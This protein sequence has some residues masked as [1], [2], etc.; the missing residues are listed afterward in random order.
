MNSRKKTK[1]VFVGPVGIGGDN[2]V[3]IQS[4]TNTPTENID[5]TVAQIKALADAG[6]QIIRV[7]LP[8]QKA[9]KAFRK[10]KEQSPIPV[11]ADIH[12]QASY[13]VAAI[14]AGADKV[15]IN[16]GNIGGKEKVK[17]VVDAARQAG[18]PIRIGVNS[19]SVEKDILE[20]YGSPTP[21]ALLE[22]ALRYIAMMES[23]SFDTIVLSIKASDVLTTIDACRL[24][25]EHCE[26]P[27]HIGITESGTVRTGTIRSSVGVGALLAEGIGDTIRVSLSGDPVNEIYVAREVLKSLGLVSGPVVIACPTC[28]RT[29]IDV[30]SLAEKVEAMVAGITAPIKIAVMGCVVNG[31]GEAK[32]ADV[33]IA[34]GKDKGQVFVR[35]EPKETV[36]YDRLLEVLEKYVREMVGSE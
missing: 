3:V 33:G 35:G 18:I 23:F 27:Q 7:A 4:M 5:A 25:S 9:V 30:S 1:P 24:L 12:F 6:C 10:V 15:R 22:S 20:K 19:G 14:E 28:S 2:P 36:P 17:L 8:H 31:P 29:Q 32:E 34:G 21:R 13:A 16:P 11:V 26:Y